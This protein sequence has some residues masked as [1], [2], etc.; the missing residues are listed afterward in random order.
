MTKS[1]LGN[2]ALAVARVYDIAN[3]GP[4]NR[5]VANG[6][7]VHNSGGEKLNLQNL[8]RGGALRR[9]MR[10]PEGHKV[11]TCDSSQIEARVLA[12]VAGQS[13]LVESFRAGG[14]VYSEFAS[15]VYGY[16]VS[17]CPETKKERQVGKVCILG[18]GYGLGAAKFP[19]VLRIMGGVTMAP[20]EAERV[21]ALYRQINTKI[22]QYWSKAGK[23]LEAMERGE[24]G[25]LDGPVPLRY[26]GTKLYLPNGL[27]IQ[28]PHLRRAESGMVYDVRRGRST[29][30]KYI[31]GGKAV[32]NLVQGLAR[33]IV[34]DQ[35]AGIDKALR[36]LQ[37]LDPKHI[38]RVVSTV[39]DEVVVIAPTHVAGKIQKLME[40]IMS[41]APAWATDLPV[42]CEADMGDSYGDSK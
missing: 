29:E 27:P 4:H 16:P 14:D 33:I 25:V 20:E 36:K 12:Y 1:L 26:E 40:K 41:K 9:A 5:F 13:D 6:K 28:Y 2:D 34:F 23:M 19:D 10:A 8:P 24:S 32:E 15:K 31:Y 39:H 7:L 22:K 38:Y 17:N 37:A 42:A 21:V 35:M 3:C 18:L 30:V 11:I